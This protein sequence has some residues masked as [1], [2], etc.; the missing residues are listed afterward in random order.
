MTGWVLSTPTQ[1]L[2]VPVLKIGEL[3]DVKIWF[4]HY[5]V[6]RQIPEGMEAATGEA[7]SAAPRNIPFPYYLKYETN[8]E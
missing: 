8:P 4:Y 2:G 5:A 1:D 3:D 7:K 6:S